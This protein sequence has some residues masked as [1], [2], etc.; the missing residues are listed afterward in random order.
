MERSVD[1]RLGA[2]LSVTEQQSF[3]FQLVDGRLLADEVEE[4]SS[5]TALAVL[6]S[7]D[8]RKLKVTAVE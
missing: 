8:T 5:G 4:T 3:T 7:R 2:A 6:R 1:L